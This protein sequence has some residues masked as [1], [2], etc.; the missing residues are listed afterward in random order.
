MIQTFPNGNNGHLFKTSSITSLYNGPFTAS[1]PRNNFV[2]LPA[3]NERSWH[4]IGETGKGSDMVVPTSGTL[5][6]LRVRFV[7]S[8]GFDQSFVLSVNGGDA[9]SATIQSGELQGENTTDSISVTAGDVVNISTSAFVGVGTVDV[10]R[11]K[12]TVDFEPIA[13][14]EAILGAIINPGDLN[15][16]IGG[17]RTYANLLN[18]NLWEGT[19]AIA[20]VFHAS[21]AGTIKSFYVH[22]GDFSGGGDVTWSLYRN[23]SEE[24]SSVITATTGGVNSVT[25]LSIAFSAGDTFTISAIT[26]GTVTW[27]DN[28]GY[29]SD[30]P[31]PV[32][33]SIMYNPVVDGEYMVGGTINNFLSTTQNTNEYFSLVGGSDDILTIEAGTITAL[34]GRSVTLKGFRVDLDVAPGVG[35]AREFRT[36]VNGA[37]GA[38]VVTI[39]GANT[40]GTD[41]TNTDSFVAN[42]L[43]NIV[44]RPTT[45]SAASSKASWSA[46]LVVGPDQLSGQAFFM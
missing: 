27:S 30:N 34:V 44:T 18:P 3:V 19:E 14:N 9:M 22:F 10:G 21:L 13:A 24:A 37:N 5:S 15:N 26:N 28:Y 23:G 45:T 1:Y 43:I 42:D 38:S 17:S 41:S 8:I 29:L 35:E 36:R 46:V 11:P 2:P 7:S 33:W 32:S 12:Y 39:T 20:R 25:G 4:S 6:N 31:G 40:T 16:V